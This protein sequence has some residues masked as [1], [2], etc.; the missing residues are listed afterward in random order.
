MHCSGAERWDPRPDL[1][2][3]DS[4]GQID[5]ENLHRLSDQLIPARSGAKPVFGS[6]SA[7]L[8]NIPSQFTQFFYSQA[9]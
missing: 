7:S 3:K 2:S 1:G 4:Q 6:R 5:D 8:S 9:P